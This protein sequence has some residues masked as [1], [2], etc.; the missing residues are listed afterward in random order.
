[1]GITARV[2][3]VQ[4]TVESMLYHPITNARVHGIAGS[5]QS[6]SACT[7]GFYLLL[8]HLRIY[9]YY[10]YTPM[11]TCSDWGYIL[12]RPGQLEG[13]MYATLISAVLMPA[14]K[15]RREFHI[16]IQTQDQEIAAI[17]TKLMKLRATQLGHNYQSPTIL[18]SN[19]HTQIGVILTVHERSICEG[20][21]YAMTQQ[22]RSSK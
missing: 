21:A 15:A 20:M 14:I 5:T 17:M 1:M 16:G 2:I 22:V 7:Y 9:P 10:T 18:P 11:H 4:R 12:T 3:E 8:I 19:W 13:C 6:I